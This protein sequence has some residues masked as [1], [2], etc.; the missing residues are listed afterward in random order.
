M[1]VSVYIQN[2]SLAQSTAMKLIFHPFIL[3]GSPEGPQGCQRQET[4]PKVLSLDPHPLPQAKQNY[5]SSQEK[6]KSKKIK[7]ANCI[8]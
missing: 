6:N 2:N 4:V 1:Y 5:F 8:T 3:Y 7:M